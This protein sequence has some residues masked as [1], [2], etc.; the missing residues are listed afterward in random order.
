MVGVQGD[1][2]QSVEAQRDREAARPKTDGVA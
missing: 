2:A 1:G